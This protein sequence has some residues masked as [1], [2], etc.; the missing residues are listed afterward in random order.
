M[1]RINKNKFNTYGKNILLITCLNIIRDTVF[2]IINNMFKYF[3][4]YYFF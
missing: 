2:F 3:E 4:A 1:L